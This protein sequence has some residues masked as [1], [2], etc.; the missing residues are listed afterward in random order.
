MRIGRTG[1][2]VMMTETTLELMR[3]HPFLAGLTT[4]QLERL[5]YWG[6][7][8]ILHGGTKL[9]EQGSRADRFWLIVEGAVQLT[10]AVPGRDDVVVDALGPQSVLG[11]S[12]LFAPYRWN[13]TATTTELTHALVFDGP[14]IR[15]VCDS[16]PV[17]GLEL[18]RRFIHVVFERLQQTRQRLLEAYADQ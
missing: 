5:S 17:L 16:D 14:G 9:F 12:W 3:R 18:H 6:H 1:G 4:R 8:A 2:A 7:G 11:W 10:T 13:F 15:E